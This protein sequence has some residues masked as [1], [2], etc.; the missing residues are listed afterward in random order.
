MGFENADIVKSLQS[1]ILRMEGFKPAGSSG[2]DMGLGVINEAFPN[3]VFPQG[4]VHEFLSGKPEDDAATSG[5][6]TGLLATLMDSKGTAM[7]IS[8]C[9]TIYPPALKFFGVQPDRVIFAD[10]CRE[11]DVLWAMEEALKCGALTAVV[12]DLPDLSFIASR[13]LQLAVEQS[14]VTG[15]VIRHNVRKAG[16]TASVSRWRITSVPG[17]QIDDLPGLGFP[18]WKVELLRI[19]NGKS[20]AWDVR[21]MNGRFQ[22]VPRLHSNAGQ[23][24]R[25][26]G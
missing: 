9:R 17:E 16:V 5:F 20:G 8:S 24:R 10:L 7:W 21:W 15:F 4:A 12:A 23:Q 25:K 13:R 6:I 19:R 2:M 22:T 1:E 11:R 18:Q 14:M 3:G 26:A